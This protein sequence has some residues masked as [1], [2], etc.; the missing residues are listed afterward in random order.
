VLAEKKQGKMTD[1]AV[2]PRTA[3]AASSRMMEKGAATA[4]TL[5]GG[6]AGVA[7]ARSAASGW[8]G[9]ENTPPHSHAKSTSR[10]SFVAPNE[11]RRDT[12]RWEMRQ[13]MANPPTF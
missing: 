13:R 10:S 7:V 2:R 6:S 11:K 4:A 12:L 8:G 3:G 9:I 5:K 1:A